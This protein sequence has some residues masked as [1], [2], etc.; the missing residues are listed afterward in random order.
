ML[1]RSRCS[2]RLCDLVARPPSSNFEDICSF[3]DEIHLRRDRNLF[4]DLL[5]EEIGGDY[6]LL[7]TDSIVVIP[8][9]GALADFYALVVPRNHVLSFA[10]LPAAVD[11]E[12]ATVMRALREW[13]LEEAESP[14]VL[15]EHGSFSFRDKGGACFDHA[16]IHAVAARSTPT[17]FLRRVEKVVP[18]SP[19]E[20]WLPAARE[21]VRKRHRSYWAMSTE[22]AGD[23]L[24]EP[25]DVPSQFFRRSL[26]EWL[27]MDEQWDAVMYPQVD[28]VAHM[29][30]RARANPLRL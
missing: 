15:F 19:V 9:L 20:Q 30:E 18:M 4:W 6:L 10:Y 11:D 5:G 21:W 26:A 13:F 1:R 8:C 7:E 17:D 24:G 16:H 27:H 14:P 12:L 29:I 28:R 22:E 3:C 25:R 2:C 23:Y